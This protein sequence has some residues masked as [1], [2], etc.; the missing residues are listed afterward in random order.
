[1]RLKTLGGVVAFALF[2][3]AFVPVAS[4]DGIRPG[5]ARLGHDH[6]VVTPS[7]GRDHA[8]L[9]KAD[10]AR[11][12]GPEDLDRL[13]RQMMGNRN[14][15]TANGF[16][17]PEAPQPSSGSSAGSANSFQ[18]VTQATALQQVTN[19]LA[20][21]LTAPVAQPGLAW[22]SALLPIA[23]A[24][25]DDGLDLAVS[26]FGSADMLATPEPASLVLLGSGLAAGVFGMRRRKKAAQKGL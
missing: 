8:E 25:A 6:D 11:M 26:Q 4:A 23:G 13:Y 18:A 14:R 17:G 2:S 7:G 5:R 21:G 19:T 3:S 24:L 15:Q 10:A 12:R 9:L 16:R 20:S 22:P 1:M